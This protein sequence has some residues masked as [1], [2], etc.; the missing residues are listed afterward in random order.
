MVWT[1]V[2]KLTAIIF[3]KDTKVS[4][5]KNNSLHRGM[6]NEQGVKAAAT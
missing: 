3:C 4:T 1:L 6:L 2:V 5:N